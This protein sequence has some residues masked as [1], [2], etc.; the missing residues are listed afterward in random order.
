LVGVA[1]S[2]GRGLGVFTAPSGTPLFRPGE[3]PPAGTRVDPFAPIETELRAR[4]AWGA[5]DVLH[6]HL[7][8]PAALVMADRLAR[9]SAHLRVVATLHVAAVFPETTETVRTLRARRTPIVF[10]APSRAALASYGIEPDGETAH[11]VPNGVDTSA[12]AY[13]ERG[14]AHVRLAWAGRRSREKGLLEALAIAKLGGWPITIAGARA[15]EATAEDEA[16]ITTAI[17]DGDVEDLGLV[18]RARMPEVFARATAL[19]VTSSIPETH[20]LVAIEAFAAGT[21]VVAFDVGAIREVVDDGI[22]GWVVP[23]G[24]VAAA[25]D[26][27]ARIGAITRARCR[28]EAV[29]RFDHTRVVDRFLA[30]YGAPSK[31][32]R[33][34]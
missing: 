33:A 4:M 29:A 9:D 5:L 14:P 22:T 23:A 3:A 24:D 13:A 1:G 16:R 8:D 17:A 18:P 21:P 30:I 11:V 26:A 6:L 25:R 15:P 31:N 20:S 7:I 27:V 28:A 19:L 34:T 32:Q 2:G 12:I 10:T